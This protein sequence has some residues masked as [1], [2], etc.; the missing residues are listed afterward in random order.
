MSGLAL[1]WHLDGR[2]ARAGDLDAMLAE[3]ARRGPDGERREVS[4]SAALGHRLL[5]TTPEAASE[6]MP[7]RDALTGRWI[8]GEIR[9]DNR[10][11]LLARFGLAGV[12]RVVGDGELVLR[13]FEQWGEDCA[14]HLL[15]DFAFAIWDPAKQYVFA[16]RD[17]TG[18][19]QFIYSHH[20]GKAFICASSA[21]AV[22]RA[23]AT[24]PPLNQLKLARALID[25][26][27]ADFESTF[28]GGVLR[29]PPA[30]CLIVDPRG[31]RLRRYWEMTPPATLRLRSDADYADA[32]RDVLAIA[33]R[34]RL[35]GQ[36]QIG[37]ML[38]INR[39]AGQRH[40]EPPFAD[41]LGNRPAPEHRSRG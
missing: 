21:L 1:Y 3:M 30:H 36:E 12:G 8:T 18:M 7:F 9:L 2:P 27:A 14:C 26:E 15:G 17:H 29:L 10:S 37:A 4:G 16:A 32:F 31:L 5:V 23:H 38:R 11:D 25:S 35:R 41:I 6:P 24:F 34:D 13:A 28:F 22:S 39:G 33:V 20:P 40:D 19:R